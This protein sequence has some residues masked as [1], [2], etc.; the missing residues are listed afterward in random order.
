MKNRLITMAG[1]LALLAVVGKF[2]A[3]PALA[4]L[5]RAALVKNVD[6][7]GRSPYMQFQPRAHSA[8]QRPF[9]FPD[10]AIRRSEPDDRKRTNAPLF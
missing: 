10:A 4:K 2:Y 1:A 6:E 3:T 7:K 5:V 9:G 8:G